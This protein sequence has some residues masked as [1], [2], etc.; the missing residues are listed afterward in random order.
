MR[1]PL[2]DQAN[3]WMFASLRV[4]SNQFKNNHT[5]GET[6][7]SGAN[8]CINE[9]HS[10]WLDWKKIASVPL[11]SVD[12][13]TSFP[14]IKCYHLERAVTDFKL[15]LAQSY[16]QDMMPDLV[17]H[18]S[19]PWLCFLDR[20]ITVLLAVQRPG[21][22]VWLK[23]A[24]R[25]STIANKGPNSLCAN[26][27]CCKCTLKHVCGILCVGTTSSSGLGWAETVSEQ[28]RVGSQL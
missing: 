15:L 19:I 28:F 25:T 21:G 14:T 24:C 20:N 18:H 9:S 5:V 1:F 16:S 8:E 22:H 2:T 11:P 27:G 26:A 6:S 12:W 4:K 17:I 23:A 7:S 13:V 10:L 3:I